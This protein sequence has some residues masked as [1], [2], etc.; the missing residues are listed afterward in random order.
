MDRQPVL[1]RVDVRNAGARHHE[2]Q[3]GRRDR[4]VE[5]VVRRAR[6][7]GARLAIGIGQGAHDLG[8]VFRGRAVSRNDGARR[9]AP[10][11]DGKRLGGGAGRRRADAGTHRAGIDDAAA[12]QGAAVDQAVAGDDLRFTR[13]FSRLPVCHVFLLRGVGGRPNIFEAA[14]GPGGGGDRPSIRFFRRRFHGRGR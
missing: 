9:R 12:E 5:Q 2:M 11:I 7:G 14:G 6:I 10:R 8:F 3:P 1:G 4:A 13:P